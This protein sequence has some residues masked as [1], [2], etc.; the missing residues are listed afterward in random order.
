M[1][2]ILCLFLLA[3]F[4]PAAVR[5]EGPAQAV[6]FRNDV[7]PILLERCLACHG[8]MKSAGGFRLDSYERLMLKTGAAH[9]VVPGKVAESDL[10]Q[11]LTSQEGSQRMPKKS[12]P[13]SAQ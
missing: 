10:Y 7:A 13:L 1:R 11:L 6:S 4:L 5:A 2:Y 3:M 8:P 12:D 9:A